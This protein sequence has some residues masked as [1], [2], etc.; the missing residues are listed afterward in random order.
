[1]DRFLEL[2]LPQQLVVGLFVLAALGGAAYFGVLSPLD[3]DIASARR[4]LAQRDQEYQKLSEFRDPQKLKRLEED[5]KTIREQ[6]AARLKLMPPGDELPD[7]IRSIKDEADSVN[8]DVRKFEVGKR[9]DEQHYARIPVTVAL[10]GPFPR[11]VEFLGRLAGAEKRMVNVR[12][13][14]VKKIKLGRHTVREL[15][16][17]SDVARKLAELGAKAS[18][19]PDFAKLYAIRSREVAEEHTVVSAKFTIWAYSYTGE[20][21]SLVEAAK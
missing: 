18:T 16:G 1:M 2:P 20:G 14:T 17:D 9:V 3:D 21:A 4:Q 5:L 7:L 12:D 11:L 13:I 10:I 8:L 15:L 6:I 19:N